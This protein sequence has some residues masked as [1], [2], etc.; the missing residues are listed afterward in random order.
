MS[1]PQ[2]DEAAIQAFVAAFRDASG[3]DGPLGH[4]AFGDTPALQDEL[5]QLVREGPKRATAGYHDGEQAPVEGQHDVVLDASGTPLCVIRTEEVRV[6]PFADRDPAFAWDEGEDDRTL[7]SWTANHRAYFD[8]H[9]EGFGDD[10]LVDFER[11]VVVHPELPPPPPLVDADGVVVRPVLP[12]ERHWVASVVR[13]TTSDDGWPVDRCP[14]LLA[15]HQLRTAGVLVFVPSPD[16]VEVVATALLDE[17]P[18]VEAGLQ[19]ALERL[20]ATHRWGHVTS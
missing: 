18:A 1:E 3:Y 10:T 11:F 19:A 9:V 13:D 2:P 12:P 17:D 14:A 5:G 16:R 8:R 4:V 6:L 7:D 20:R 15:R